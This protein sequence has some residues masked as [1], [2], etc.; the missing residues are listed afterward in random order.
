MT[1]VRDRCHSGKT[2]SDETKKQRKK[3]M[4]STNLSPTDMTTTLSTTES[5]SWNEILPVSIIYQ[6]FTYIPDPVSIANLECTCREF[7]RVSME[8]DLWS[9]LHDRRWSFRSNGRNSE[10]L[11]RGSLLVGDTPELYAVTKSE[12]IRRYQLDQQTQRDLKLLQQQPIASESLWTRLLERGR[13]VIDV[14]WN[15]ININQDREN[16][17]HH[18]HES[19]RVIFL[20]QRWELFQELV[21]FYYEQR[22][23]ANDN[24][25][26]DSAI[27]LEQY[28]LLTSFMCSD[29]AYRN[30]ETA[31]QQT[32]NRLDEIARAVREYRSQNFPQSTSFTAEQTWMALNHIF[33]QV[34][35]FTGNV[36]D[37]YN[38]HNS[39][40]QFALT[41]KKA[42]PITLAILYKCLARRLD[43]NVHIVGLPGHIVISLPALEKYMDLFRDGQLLERLD[44]IRMVHS[45][46]IPFAE[47]YLDS[48]TPEQTLQRVCNNLRN[49]NTGDGDDEDEHLTSQRL[50]MVLLT[51]LLLN[52][53][54]R[55]RLMEKCYHGL[56]RRWN[57]QQHSA[58]TI[59]RL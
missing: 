3:E 39:L 12:F 58:W 16:Q 25:G 15:V 34:E 1:V 59:G 7:R 9:I 28:A 41:T 40:L 35:G 14:C 27:R 54:D 50:L 30:Y 48:L 53:M 19:L 11:N 18:R 22:A 36:E 31:I 23:R 4:L 33:F 37:Y 52:D 8:F 47:R 10:C 21:A 13:E 26:I 55:E 56:R 20:L 45:Y 5:S 44:I 57:S 42:I 38:F 29:T 46:G 51:S 2:Q 49:H 43:L 6:I 32:K 17:N 24:E